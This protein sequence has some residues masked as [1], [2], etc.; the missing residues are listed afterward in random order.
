MALDPAIAS[1][2]SNPIGNL[3]G[4]GT[5][6]SAPNPAV[7]ENPASTGS[8]SG[9]MVL[10]VNPS[11]AGSPSITEGPGTFDSPQSGAPDTTGD[12]MAEGTRGG[13]GYM[14]SGLEPA[15][16]GAPGVFTPKPPNYLN[17]YNTGLNHVEDLLNKIYT[18]DD[19]DRARQPAAQPQPQAAPAATQQPDQ[20]PV[21]GTEHSPDYYNTRDYLRHGDDFYFQNLTGHD[22][23]IGNGTTFGLDYDTGGNDAEDNGKGAFGYNTRDKN[24]A[25]ASL[26]V[27]VIKNSIGDYENDPK[28]FE[29]IKRGDYQV[30]VQNENGDSTVVPIV[31]SGPADWTGNAIDLTYKTSH[32]MGTQ[33]KAKIGYQ[34]IGPDGEVVPI[35]GYHHDTVA[36]AKYEDHI[37][38]QRKTVG[39]VVNPTT[40]KAK[41]AEAETKE[42]TPSAGTSEEGKEQE[43]VK[44]K[45][46]KDQIA[47]FFDSH[48][49]PL[50]ASK[51][52]LNDADQQVEYPEKDGSFS[53]WKYSQF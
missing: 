49:I 20:A 38:A 31:D 8:L 13:G 2:F 53:Y 23:V 44:G 37:G 42:T 28:V 19:S 51:A 12:T 46:T 10:A 40:E 22:S 15:A 4:G 27:S 34:I 29:A 3:A 35:K 41:P 14:A 11:M 1:I 45:P 18:P 7:A 48:K 33:G 5:P 16:K 25:G 32:D 47:K 43:A 26:P 24:L 50:D 21:E 36:P 9:S 30:M 39:A 17:T 52:R 6:S